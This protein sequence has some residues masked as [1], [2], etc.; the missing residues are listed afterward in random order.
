MGLEERRKDLRSAIVGTATRTGVNAME[1]AG[2]VAKFQELTGRGDLA[3]EVAPQIAKIAQIT[4]ATMEDVAAT[5]AFTFVGADKR[6]KSTG[7]AMQ[8][9]LKIMNNIGAQGMQGIGFALCVDVG[10]GHVV[11]HD[12][13][14]GRYPA[15]SDVEFII[16]SVGVD[17]GDKATDQKAH[18]DA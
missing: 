3:S 10:N 4:N 12:L 15:G 16:R 5:M 8:E 11:K 9:T 17:E 1:L 2:G 18:D 13:H 7:E 14:R 6:A